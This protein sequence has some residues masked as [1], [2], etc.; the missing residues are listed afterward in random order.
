MS[1]RVSKRVSK[2]EEKEERVKKRDH[3]PKAAV[4]PLEAVDDPLDQGQRDEDLEQ[5]GKIR[6]A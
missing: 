1:K 2:R 3:R 5:A 4:D 6:A